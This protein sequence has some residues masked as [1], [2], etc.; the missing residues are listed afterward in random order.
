MAKRVVDGVVLVTGASSGVRAGIA[1]RFHARGVGL[2]SAAAIP[3]ALLAYGMSLHGAQR[4]GIGG[5]APDLILV[6]GLKAFGQPLVAFLVASAGL[7]LE[8]RDLLAA[9]PLRR[10][11]NG[12]T[13]VHLRL[14]LHPR[15]AAGP[16]RG[17]P[18]D[19]HFGAS[20]ASR[21]HPL[22]HLYRV[23]TECGAAA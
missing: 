8:G 14:A 16:R 23:S 22:T 7:G 4:L 12:A 10:T 19:R 3:V 13:G 2:L 1:A 9:T 20:D 5:H 15:H 11:A 6:V 17:I 21:L 18:V